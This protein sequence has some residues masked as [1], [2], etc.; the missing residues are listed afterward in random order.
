LKSAEG[1]ETEKWE[2]KGRKDRGL[3]FSSGEKEAPEVQDF[4]TV[5]TYTGSNFETW[6]VLVGTPQAKFCKDENVRPIVR[7]TLA[8]GGQ[9]RLYMPAAYG[10]SSKRS[11]GEI[12]VPL[13]GVDVFGEFDA[14]K[15][16][17][18]REKIRMALVEKHEENLRDRKGERRDG[19]GG[20]ERD[21]GGCERDE[22]GCER[23][24]GGYER[25]VGECVRDEGEHEGQ[26]EG[27]LEGQYEGEGVGQDEEEEYQEQEG[28]EQDCCWRE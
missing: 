25:D 8:D 14:P 9:V 24:E 16:G 5:D 6:D 4:T 17:M 13:G 27:E 1:R 21:E 10:V 15:E 2:K 7:A 22:G 26:C 19:R 18:R 3:N 11:K 12:G 28:E 20:C 23:D